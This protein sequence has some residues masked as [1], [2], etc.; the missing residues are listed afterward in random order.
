MKKILLTISAFF[1]LLSCTDDITNLNE[2]TKNPSN[3]PAEYLFSNAQKNLVDQMTSTNVNN[4]VFRLFVQHWTETTYTDES[5]YDITNRTIPDNHFRVIYR[6]VLK[7][8]AESK[9]ILLS[10]VYVGTTQE[11]ADQNTVRNNK[12]AIIDIYAA[13]SYSILVDTFGNIPYSE[14]LD[15]ENHPNPKY[16]D[17]KT[18]YKDL[19][20]KL[21]ASVNSM[22]LTKDSFGTADLIY[23]GD[24]SKW[25]KFANSLRLKLA[26]NLD[27][28][29]HTYA[30]TQVLAAVTSG[31][32]TNSADNAKLKYLSVQP[33]TNPIYVDV[34]A[35]GRDDFVPTSTIIN[36]MNALS[37]PRRSSYFTLIGSIYEGGIPGDGNAFDNFSH[38]GT[39]LLD[40]TFESLLL[41]Y[42]EVEFLLAE[43]VERG[44][45]V[46]GTAD[47]HYTNAVTAS[48]NYWNVSSTNIAA[49]LAQPSV[50]Y[51]TATGTWKQ[52]IGEQAYLGL[53]NRGFEAWTSFRRLDFPVLTAPA[54]AVISVVPRRYTYPAAEQ[55]LNSTNNAA[56]ATAIGGD[57]MTTKLFWDIY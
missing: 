51:A 24:M 10:E 20:S 49:Y 17:A 54:D 26:I 50:A 27:D 41:D 28:V 45:A 30:T 55:T 48:L 37:D 5:N 52:K 3:V 44:I 2:D 47:T 4:N 36:K 1:L 35:S 15:I 9:K 40:P 31:V 42:S 23:G 34:V 11:I 22:N 8:L 12:I 46:G 38:I 14:A 13:Y 18:I 33:N 6:D 21:T 25:K 16:D 19:I 56:A 39:Q 53:Y 43:A 7:N 32:I 29:D 57:L